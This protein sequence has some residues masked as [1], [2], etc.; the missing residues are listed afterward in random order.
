MYYVIHTKAERLRSLPRQTPHMPRNGTHVWELEP[1]IRIQ[2]EQVEQEI[3]I[4]IH[5]RPKK[6][7]NNHVEQRAK[8]IQV[9]R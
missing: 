1:Y 2:N 8:S 4:K 6:D 7:R 5:Y 9:A 3:Q